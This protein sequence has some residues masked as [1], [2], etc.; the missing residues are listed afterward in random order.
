MVFEGA[1]LKKA[2]VDRKAE[3]TSFRMGT[4]SR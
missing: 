2:A 1:K 4:F 3:K